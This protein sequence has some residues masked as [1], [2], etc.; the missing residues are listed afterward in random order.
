MSEAAKRRSEC[1]LDT[2]MSEAAK[3]RSECRLDT[4]MSGGPLL[5]WRPALVATD[6]D[7]TLL[8]SD[9]EVSDANLAALAAV[10]AAGVP[11][12]VV[13]GRPWRWMAPVLLQLPAQ[14]SAI[15]ANGALVVDLAD[16]RVLA[17]RPM[18]VGD[19]LTCVR[20]LRAAIPG[21]VFAMEYSDQSAFGREPAYRARWPP[22]EFR[23]GA[24]EQLCDRPVAKLLLRSES[25]GADA[26]HALAAE[27]VRH[28]LVTLTHSSGQT[29][30]VEISAA[31]VDKG[32]ALARY[33]EDL[34][35]A[36][37]DVLAFGDGRND[38]SMLSW[39]GHGVAVSNAHPATRAVA[40]EIGASND[41]DA[42]AAVLSRW[43]C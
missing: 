35:I 38:L 13:T 11:Y 32:A 4:R 8:G 7:G 18:T 1:K 31:G 15:L 5:G 41:E 6:L 27:A 33:A 10:A 14:G 19:T 2:R 25:H 23:C 34:G 36:G 28:Q 20:V 29:G 17:S 3:W 16:G 12:V 43:F 39:A 42:V 24:A 26:L 9:G 22:G 30:L 21:G 40:D 37:R